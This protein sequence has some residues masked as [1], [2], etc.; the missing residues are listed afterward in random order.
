MKEGGPYDEYTEL[1]PETETEY[2]ITGLGTGAYY[3]VV[4]AIDTSGNESSDSKEVSIRRGGI[5]WLILL[6]E[7]E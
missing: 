5:P 1:I 3:F 7:D 6:L 2:I 4:T